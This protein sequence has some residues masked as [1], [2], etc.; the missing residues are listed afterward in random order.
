M[1]KRI[2][3]VWF[4]N[5]LRIQDNEMLSRISERGGVVVPVYCFD[6][7]YYGQTQYG[8]RKTGLLRARFINESVKDLQN[9]FRK[10]GGDL[11]IKHGF[12]EEVIPEIAVH[13]N[14]DEVYHHRE[15]AEEETHVSSLVETSL[16]KHKLNLR[17]FIG[18][19]LYHKEDLPFPIKDIPD[20]FHTFKKKTERDSFIRESFLTPPKMD[21]PTHFIETDVPG[22]ED[23]GYSAKEIQQ[24]PKSAFVGGEQ[25]AHRQ[26]SSFLETGFK[27]GD[28][29]ML[30]PWLS[31][32]CLSVHSFYHALIQQTGINMK[33][34]ETIMLGLWWRDY[35]RFMF[36]KHKNIF[37]RIQ[38]FADQLPPLSAD[39]STSLQ[40]WE[41]G[42]TPNDEVNEIMHQLNQT[43]YIKNE[44]R[45]TAAY[46]LIHH[47][48]VNWL[49][50]AYYFEEKLIDYNPSN[51]YGN[52]AHV[53]GV[54]SSNKH[55]LKPLPL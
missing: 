23:L 27:E 31:L 48:Q 32:G 34:K 7:R 54:G 25:E 1:N 40:R 55:N 17:H 5:D 6:P 30:S 51:N 46:Y 53:A 42:E 14:A 18:H 22:L 36:K 4:R 12:P 11:L 10:I 29:S 37:F 50:G 8:T 13:F 20:A 26:L 28:G 24:T 15:V 16:W 49:F 52:W 43:G 45:V 3:L 44:D 21:F 33:E 38:G 39:Q 9:S 47:L 2:I 41:K 19:T 35:Y